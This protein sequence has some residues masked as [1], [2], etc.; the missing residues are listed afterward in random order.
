M[1]RLR[2]GDLKAAF[3]Q[4]KYAEAWVRGMRKQRKR[5]CCVFVYVGVTRMGRDGGIPPWYSR[6]SLFEQ[7]LRNQE[8]MPASHRP[9]ASVVMECMDQVV[10]R[11]YDSCCCQQVPI[12]NAR[13]EIMLMSRELL[14]TERHSLG[15]S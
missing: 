7:E 11:V 10:L 1:E 13:A 12:S 5:H 4:F 15:G 2:T 3:E 14:P 9:G 8:S 6:K